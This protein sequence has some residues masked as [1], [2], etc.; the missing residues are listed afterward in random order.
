MLGVMLSIGDKVNRE[1]RQVGANI[2]I[3]PKAA[4]LTGGIGAQTASATAYI[5]EAEVANLGKIFWHLNITGISPSLLAHDGS[6]QVEGVW[7]SHDSGGLPTVN[8]AWVVRGHWALDNKAECMVGEGVAIHNHWKPGQ[9]ITLFGNT[10]KIAGLI[11]SGDDAE[12]RV[13]LPLARVQQLTNRPG[14]IDRIDVAALTKPE[15]AFARKDPKTMSPAQY[16][17]WHCTNYVTSIA[18]DIEEALPGTQ[19]RAVRRIADSEG[20]ILGNIG[21]LMSLITLA[22][23]LSA[24]LTVWSLTATTMLERRG[25]IAIMQA[26]GAGRGMVAA[27]LGVEISLIG[28][29]GGFIGAFAGLFLA[30]YVGRAVFHESIE[31]SPVLP[32][33]IVL[34]AVFIA[35]A[36]AFQPLRHAVRLEPAVILREG[37]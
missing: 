13:F 12:D 23:L 29:A 17:L 28:L 20:K 35:L 1:L 21:G 27:L 36:G 9:E 30:K 32:L 18:L 3:T 33:L 22:A 37:V 10:F 19:A 6:T 11:S 14:V 25:E 34:A 5:P 2:V 7:F 26:I 24:G 16:E 4:A 8:P 15:D 31:V